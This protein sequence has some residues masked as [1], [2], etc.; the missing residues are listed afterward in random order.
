MICTA[1]EPAGQTHTALAHFSIQ[2]DIDAGIV[3]LALQARAINPGIRFYLSM[4]SAPA[5]MKTNGRRTG[6][7]YVKPEYYPAL[8]RYQRMAI[9]AYRAPGIALSAMT[10][11]NEPAVVQAYPTGQWTGAQMRDYIK[12]SGEVS[13]VAFRNEP[14]PR[15][16]SRRP[17][18]TASTRAG[19]SSPAGVEPARAAVAAG[20]R[21]RT[22]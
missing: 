13:N 9:Q 5:W 18:G 16:R 10:P 2:K 3:A 19:R 11:Q 6:G 4:W 7:G 22:G 12:T 21:L 14:E 8:A 20:H 17:P 1:G 15:T